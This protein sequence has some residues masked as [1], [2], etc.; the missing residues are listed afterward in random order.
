MIV[1]KFNG[2]KIRTL[3]DLLAAKESSHDGYHLIE[4]K[5]GDSLQRMILDASE[6]NAATERVLKRYGIEK[7]RSISAPAPSTGKKLVSD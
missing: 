3:Q 4:F 2:Q 1:D 6:L 5:E 7:D